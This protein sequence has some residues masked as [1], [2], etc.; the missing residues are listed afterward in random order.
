MSEAAS[1][2]FI[3]GYFPHE[4][5]PELYRNADACIFPSVNE[6]VGLSVLEAMVT[7]LPVA[8]SNKGTLPEITGGKTLYFDSDNVQEMAD[9][10]E[11][12]IVDE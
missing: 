1:D 5:F 4:N 7:G 10:I 3:T 6:G 2:I 9:V 8:C 12:I 11:K